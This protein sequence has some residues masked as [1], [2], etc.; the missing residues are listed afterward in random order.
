MKKTYE[1]IVLGCRIKANCPLTGPGSV[2]GVPSGEGGGL[3]K[4][5]EMK[6]EKRVFSPPLLLANKF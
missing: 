5:Y 2:E 3:S 1:R 4:T 6:H